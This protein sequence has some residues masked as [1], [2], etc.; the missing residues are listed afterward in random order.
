MIT[1]AM[2]A[3]AAGQHAHANPQLNDPIMADILNQG[4]SGKPLHPLLLPTMYLMASIALFEA[5][6]HVAW[7]DTSSMVPI[8]CFNFL[9]SLNLF[10]S[11]LTMFWTRSNSALPGNRAPVEF[12]P[13]TNVTTFL[14][15]R[16]LIMSH[17]NEGK[18]D[19]SFHTL[20]VLQCLLASSIIC[21]ALR[22]ILARISETGEQ[23]DVGGYSFWVVNSALLVGAGT[24]FL[25]VGSVTLK[26]LPLLYYDLL[27]ASVEIINVALVIARL[28]RSAVH[29]HDV[30]QLTA[31]AQNA[32]TKK[33]R[34]T[35]ADA[36]TLS[37]CISTLSQA[38]GRFIETSTSRT[39]AMDI[40]GCTITLCTSCSVWYTLGF[41]SSLVDILLFLSCRT[42]SINLFKSVSQHQAWSRI[43]TDLANPALFTSACSTND[44]KDVC[45][46]CLHPYTL[47]TYK[48]KCGHALHRTCAHELLRRTATDSKCPLCRAG[49]YPCKHSVAAPGAAGGDYPGAA[50]RE[51]TVILGAGQ[52]NNSNDNNNEDGDANEGGSPVA[53]ANAP[54]A[55][56]LLR[57]TMPSW[58]P[59]PP[60]QFE[61][62][63]VPPTDRPAPLFS[64]FSNLWAM[65]SQSDEDRLSFVREMFPDRIEA[66]V[67]AA[68]R[69]RTIDEAV[70]ILSGAN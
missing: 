11:R 36:K 57:W 14:L 62:N 35:G 46:I 49:V 28:W 47:P 34:D 54:P 4:G 44:L 6:S 7:S 33:R 16:Y 42:S 39:N 55:E 38:H 40:A 52:V 13:F 32:T 22:Q 60:M 67:R 9:A 1:A 3:Q 37:T 41:T 64:M 29:N 21:H 63:R 2:A 26:S 25:A 12:Y 8:C 19:T 58:L 61:I 69:G 5:S 15:Y 27:A 20:L 51:S 50:W 66:E 53:G 65:I 10:L 48:M 59:I 24:V 56:P 31:D 18:L 70:V 17:L 45:P 68:M 30:A 23:F 43:A